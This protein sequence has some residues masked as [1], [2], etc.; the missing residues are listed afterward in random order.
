[1]QN[2]SFIKIVFTFFSM[3]MVSNELLAQSIFEKDA[4]TLINEHF[5][6]SGHL[7]K[8]MQYQLNDDVHDESAGIRHI[9]AQQQVNG[10][11]VKDALLGLHISQVYG[12]VSP[13]DQFSEPKVN[14]AQPTIT[15]EKAVLIVL[16]S[17]G[18]PQNGNLTIKEPT[19]GL[20][21][22]T[23]FDKSTLAADQIKARLM[24]HKGLKEGQTLKLTWE[25]QI[26][27]RDRQH[28]WLC[29]TDALNGNILEKQD[30]V[31]KCN[32]GGVETDG[33]PE[34]LK[35]LEKEH[36][37]L[38]LATAARTEAY[39]AQQ[40]LRKLDRFDV[41]PANK[42]IFSASAT[43]LPPANTYLVLAQP[44]EVPSD[45]TATNTQTNVTTSGDAT[46]SPYGWT[47]DDGAT[48]YA[49]TRGNNVWAFYDPSPGP[50][51][52]VPSPAPN[53]S[54]Q[55]SNV[56]PVAPYTYNYPWDLTQEPE[57]STAS[58]TNQFPN[59]N[60]ATV[61]LFYWNNLMHDVFYPF[62][63]NEKGRN[64][65]TT[66][67]FSGTNR[68]GVGNDGVLAQ[69]Q[70]GG[71]TNNAN[72]LTLTDGTPGQM[73]MYLWT[74]S[75]LDNLVQ[76]S[77]VTGGATPPPSAGTKYPSLQGALYLAANESNVAFN[78][79]I[80]ARPVLNKDFIVVQK[81]AAASVGTSTEGC[82][83]SMGVGLAPANNVLGKIVLI[84]RGSCSFVEK[85]HGAQLGGAAGVIVMNNDA[86][87]PNAVLAMGGSD[88]TINTI[89]IPAVM[90]SYNKGL[91]LKAALGS[92]AII[93][94]SLKRDSPKIPKKDGDFDNGIIAHE[95]GHG[96]SSRTSPQT[97]S[98]G[99]L[100]GNEQGGEGWSDFWA[101]Y[102]TTRS[103][104]LGSVTTQ[105]PNG[106]LPDRGIGTYVFYQNYDGLGI[107]PRK[108]SIN[109]SVNE[110]VF[111]GTSKG[112]SDPSLTIPHGIGFVWCTM[113]YE[114]L[115]EMIDQYPINDN[116]YYSPNNVA[117]LASAG[118]NNVANKLILEG[119]RLQPA[120]PTF[121]QQRDGILK[122]DT[123]LYGGI[124]SC[125]IWRA[126]AK[127]G[128]GY[129][130]TDATNALGNETN[131]YQ[132][133][134]ACDPN[135][136][137]FNVKVTAPD[138]LKNATNLQY[139]IKV[140]N[141][142]S[143]ATNVTITNPI[144]AN[145]AFQSASDGGG[146][147]GSNVV[148]SGV[149][150][151]AGQ[152]VTRTVTFSVNKPTA[153]TLYFF[154]DQELGT[155][156]WAT[157]SVNPLYPW[158]QIS[159]SAYTGTT[160]WFVPDPDG[161]SDAGLA[162]AAPVA[163]PN[164]N[165]LKLYFNHMY[166]TE[167]TFDGG[168]LET[169]PS[170]VGPWTTVPQSSFESNGYPSDATVAAADNPLMY[171]SSNNGSCFGGSSGNFIESVVNLDA[172]KNTSTYFRFRFMS[173]I[174][175]PAVGWNVDNV[176]VVSNPIFVNNTVSV[177]SGVFTKTGTATTLITVNNTIVP[178]T[179]TQLSAKGQ[180]DK[181]IHINWETATESNSKGFYLERRDENEKVFVP[182]TFVESK[183]NNGSVYQ[184]IDQR[185]EIGKTYYYQLRQVD[186]DGKETVSKIVSA[187]LDGKGAG[188]KF[189]NPV[190][191]LLNINLTNI[192]DKDSE[193]RVLGIDGRLVYSVGVTS[194]DAQTLR[195]NVSNWSK[196]L[197]IVQLKT[198][199]V[200]IVN[201]LSVQ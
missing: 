114:L 177:S 3:V 150:V 62:G 159:G 84:D 74:A 32:F 166:G 97:A 115:Q 163:L 15:A 85:V 8:N 131:G 174:L 100:S 95:Y 13:S 134:P 2:C 19:H 49:Y 165:G 186:F 130:A 137:V 170:A 14:S 139:T 99:S 18:I 64:F 89:T 117:A 190:D 103:N 27:T 199:G 56:P 57:Y 98:G 167:I 198:G 143:A 129:D 140:T 184:Y 47:S 70:D 201:K 46:A 50:L 42:N 52:G 11:F 7:N 122:A 6:K 78:L 111:A 169:A 146:V 128:L 66:N 194:L 43:M 147:S 68:G 4:A 157:S 153:S 141:T 176:Y 60:A 94:G 25:T 90:V 151:P 142:A 69:S 185:V 200:S 133:P 155:A 31:L 173:D 107:R 91:E 105:H 123:L 149:S 73:Q 145:S 195:I 88:A 71:G 104:D 164:M 33:S 79:D 24:Y 113:L 182:I 121:I 102:M 93:V 125:R 77:T 178:V 82:G 29:Y 80:Y 26:Y 96:I 51:G 135:V 187:R 41:P 67:I 38:H 40:E 65:Q 168:T 1:M 108:Y 175:S 16:E 22:Q 196:G 92:G 191:N 5:Q 109:T 45:N 34:E 61:N 197:Y 37:A 36:H 35:Q 72:F 188:I 138:T 48:D 124:H 127:R 132:L 126:F 81:N 171:T 58:A 9:Y 152:T 118:G 181:T 179:L 59:R 17:L 162:T 119:I 39:I 87:N 180:P 76:I 158:T 172:F 21:Q 110:F 101:L 192:T 12:A 154:D 10:I 53:Y 20:D 44:A 28:Y 156:K 86:A 189:N 193:I 83:A 148:W 161:L 112:L 116:I 183:G 106:V 136:V 75:V 144:P 54:A 30:L 120:S 55:A 23:V 63:F 160:S